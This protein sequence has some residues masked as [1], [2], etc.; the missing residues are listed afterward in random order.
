VKG[1]SLRAL[2]ADLDREQLAGLLLHLA[3]QDPDLS[4]TIEDEIHPSRKQAEPI[5]DQKKADKYDIAARWLT[6]T[7]EAYGAAGRQ[8]EWED[9]LAGLLEQHHR[10][11][12][13]VPLLQ[14]LG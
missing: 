3:E 10:K 7:K 14:A 1:E 2:L 12:K 13:L 6:K 11:H 4:Q 8:E 9:Y 5:M